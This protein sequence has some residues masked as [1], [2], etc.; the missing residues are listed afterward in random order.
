M[1]KFY[2]LLL[3]VVTA[4]GALAQSYQPLV[5]QK[6]QDM[7]MPAVVQQDAADREVFWINNLSDCSDWMIDNAFNNGYDQ[8]VEGLNFECGD[9]EPEGP[10]AITAL[11]S[12]TSGNGFMMVDSDEFGGE[13]GGSGIENCWFQTVEPIDCSEHEFV[14][15]SFETYYYMWDNGSSDGNEYCLVEVSTD[16]VTWP[17]V[18]TFEESD[19]PGMRYELWPD[20]STQD[21]VANPTIQTFDITA[22]AGG[23]SQVWLRFRWK[24]TWGYAWMVD[25]IQLYDTPANDVRIDTYATY[26]D[27]NGTNMYE[28]SAWPQSQVTE[29]QMAAKVANAG[30]NPQPGVGLQVNVNGSDIGTSDLVDLAYQGTDTL[31]LVGYTIPS[32]I[33]TYEIEMNIVTDS[34]DENAADNTFMQS[35]EVTEY[36]FGR[37]DLTYTGVFPSTGTD[38]FIAATPFQF[39]EDATIYAVQVAIMDGSEAGTDIIAHI[40]DADLEIMFSSEELQLNPAFTNAGDDGDVTWYTFT[41]EDPYQASAGE[42]V[43]AAFE[44]YGGSD[45]QIGESIYCDDNTAFVY[46]DFGS[47]GF[48]W[49]Y[50]N[51]VPMIRLSLDPAAEDTPIGIVEQASVNFKLFQNNPNPANDVTRIR[52][53]LNQANKVSLQVRDITGKLVFDQVYGQQN[54]GTNSIELNVNAFG[55]GVYTYTLTV[56]EEQVTRKMMVK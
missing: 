15:I 35:F 49:Y 46:G 32:D 45:V 30:Y 26:T 34:I 54:T 2:L 13:E 7:R 22:G 28:Y 25:D 1:K 5:R 48:D 9:V 6:A 24:G 39:F 42:L 14:S 23:E 43:A 10:A 27:Y 8:F 33:D 56:G 44:H 18:E 21:A 47:A 36:V 38:E 19:A 55:A 4:G 16:G 12:T 3:S 41:L 51:D 20:M 50:S 29:V 31:R 37:D 53:T 52:Y 17:D 40:L 11:N